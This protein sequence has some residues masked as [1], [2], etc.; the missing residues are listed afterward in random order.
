VRYDLVEDAWK[1][2]EKSLD[3]AHDAPNPPAYARTAVRGWIGAYGPAFESTWRSVAERVLRIVS[4]YGFTEMATPD[5][6]WKDWQ[7]SWTG[8]QK[9]RKTL[10]LPL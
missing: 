9:R 5:E 10:C 6:L 8:W 1:G 7:S 3:K 2:L 4:F